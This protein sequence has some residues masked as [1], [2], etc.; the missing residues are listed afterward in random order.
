[1]NHSHS[2]NVSPARGARTVASVLMLAAASL[3]ATAA[4]PALYPGARQDSAVTEFVRNSLGTEGT[5]Y[6]SNDTLAK[7]VA[8]Y[9]KQAGVKPMGEPGA[10][11]AAFVAG[12]REE[13]N[14]ILKKTMSTGCSL[15]IT[16]QN[17]WV[18][19]RSGKRVN[20]TLI[21]VVPQR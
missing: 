18:D 16:V 3:G 8:F 12:C 4:E 6:R 20:D 14:A 5:A 1:M 17:P 15:H 11:S 19:T 9:R 10:D 7:V 2:R 21:T 13:Y